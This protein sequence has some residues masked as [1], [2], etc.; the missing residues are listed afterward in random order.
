M[1]A[2]GMLRQLSESIPVSLLTVVT[3]SCLPFPPYWLHIVNVIH[4][5]CNAHRD[6]QGK[7]ITSAVSLPAIGW[8][9]Q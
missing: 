2:V 5:K 6:K 4:Q 1:Q 3:M 8:S 7:T 9:L